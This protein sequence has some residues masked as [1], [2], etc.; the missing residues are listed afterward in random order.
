MDYKTDTDTESYID[1][2][3]DV[4]YEIGLKDRHSETSEDVPE[5][6]E[7]NIAQLIDEIIDSAEEIS[8]AK[9]VEPIKVEEIATLLDE[10]EVDTLK[11]GCSCVIC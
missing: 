7:N 4:E 11:I 3:S 8:K 10:K 5:L 9:C 1:S 6:I 2:D